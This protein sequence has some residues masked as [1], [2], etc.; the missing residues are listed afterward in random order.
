MIC[1]SIALNFMEIRDICVQCFKSKHWAHEDCMGS[2]SEKLGGVK[3]R[4]K[5]GYNRHIGP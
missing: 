4:V 3:S 5:F 1:V 2:E